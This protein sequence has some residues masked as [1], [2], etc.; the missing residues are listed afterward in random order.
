[1]KSVA[2]CLADE[3]MN[4][5]K[6]SSNSYAIKVR[7]YTI[8]LSYALLT[9]R[10]RKRTSWSAWPSPTGE[11]RPVALHRQGARQAATRA[12]ALCVCPLYAHVVCP[13]WIHCTTMSAILTCCSNWLSFAANVPTTP[14]HHHVDL[15]SIHACLLLCPKQG[16]A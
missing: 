4:A 2:E 12:H 6:G 11:D 15:L 10:R 3:L 9:R 8:A 5:A 14:S 7:L 1:V 13:L 16:A